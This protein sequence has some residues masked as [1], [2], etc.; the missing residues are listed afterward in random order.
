MPED[1]E[2]TCWLSGLARG[3]D[4]AVE[5][6]WRRYYH[7][8]VRLARTKL[9]EGR[10]R[11]ADE[12]D[13]ALSAFH[14]FCRGAAADRFPR[15]EDKHDLWK[16]LVTITARKAAKLLRRERQQKRGSGGVR[17]ESVF[18]AAG[19]R[20]KGFGI[21]EV[22]GSEPTPELAASTAEQCERLLGLLPD[23]N[24][25]QIALWK[26]EGYTNDEIAGKLRRSPRTVER[27]LERIRELWL[28]EVEP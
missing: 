28:R 9:A 6:I 13:V 2:I 24:L 25:R 11:M 26:M 21:G 8:L 15:L 19:D 7:R 3:E 22:L 23:D 20:D 17:G 5:A 18:P 12:E 16:L 4:T 14:T 10:R 1:D 27:K